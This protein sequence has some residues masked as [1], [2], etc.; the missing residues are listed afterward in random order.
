V[1][2]KYQI[3][4]LIIQTID[5]AS[6]VRIGAQEHSQKQEEKQKRGGK[7]KRRTSSC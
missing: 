4:H 1:K 2:I 6:Q 5:H 7:N 3:R